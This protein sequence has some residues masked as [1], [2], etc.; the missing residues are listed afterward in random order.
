MAVAYS[1]THESNKNNGAGSSFT[2]SNALTIAGS[3]PA[4]VILIALNSAT[5]VVTSVTVDGT[6]TGTIAEKGTHRNGTTYLSIWTI[7]G[8]A[9]S[10]H[11]IVT[12]SASV[13]LDFDAMLM[14]GADQTTPL[15]TGD[16]AYADG[17]GVTTLT[18]SAANLTANDATVALAGLSVAGDV[19]SMGPNQ[20][21]IGTSTAINYLTGY[22]IGTGDCTATFASTTGS[23]KLAFAGCR[24]AQ[25]ASSGGVAVT[26]AP[27]VVGRPFPY[28][29]GAQIR[30]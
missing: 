21:E 11:I 4:V 23:S 20:V 13:E 6:L 22:R 10:G 9:G 24:V 19:I 7:A 29:P 1:G 2:S 16:I 3:N 14:T 17:A 26:A 15:A 12:P 18:A 25:T 5:A 28:A 8:P 27:I 30:R